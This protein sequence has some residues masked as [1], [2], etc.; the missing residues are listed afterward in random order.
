MDDI[1]YISERRCEENK[2]LRIFEDKKIKFCGDNDSRWQRKKIKNKND[3]KGNE[4]R[5]EC[6]DLE[7]SK[8]ERLKILEDNKKK[9]DSYLKKL[10]ELKSER[11]L[12]GEKKVVR[13]RLD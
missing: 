2:K 4:K 11:K 10:G 13:I 1:K 7:N 3:V 12:R 8:I 6:N 5:R 9:K